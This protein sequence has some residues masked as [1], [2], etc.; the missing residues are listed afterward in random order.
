MLLSSEQTVEWE[1]VWLD[2]IEPNSTAT[3]KIK[4]DPYTSTPI[5]SS[6]LLNLLQSFRFS[7]PISLHHLFQR[8]HFCGKLVGAF[9]FADKKLNI[10]A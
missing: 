2:V 9:S 8:I 5:S 10:F 1:G 4:N 6:R 7:P 3:S